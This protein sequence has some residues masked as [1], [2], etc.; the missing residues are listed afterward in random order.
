MATQQTRIQAQMS[1]EEEKLESQVMAETHELFRKIDAFLK[2]GDVQQVLTLRG[3]NTSLAMV[4]ADALKAYVL[5]NKEKAI[6]D[7]SLAAEEIAQ[8]YAQG[9]KADA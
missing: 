5:G 4:I 1:P 2:H 8:R 6:E 7:L 3:I 9:S